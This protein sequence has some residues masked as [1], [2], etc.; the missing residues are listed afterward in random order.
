MCT[1]SDVL[2]MLLYRNF[3]TLIHAVHQ[4]VQITCFSVLF[5]TS[6]L[7]FSQISFIFY[8]FTT[9]Q[10][11]RCERHKRYRI[12]I[13]KIQ[14]H[15]KYIFDI[16]LWFFINVWTSY[17]RTKQKSDYLYIYFRCYFHHKIDERGAACLLYILIKFIGIPSLSS[18]KIYKRIII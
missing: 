7:L 8:V 4:F 1:I 16:I 15:T 10:Q 17:P 9:K 6:F 12:F 11:R 13:I 5:A 18:I 3:L 2:W 14:T